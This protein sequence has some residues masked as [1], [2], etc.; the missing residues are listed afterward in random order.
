MSSFNKED[1][2]LNYVLEKLKKEIQ[3]LN[4]ETEELKKRA[5]SL[6]FEDKKR[7]EH[8]NV[9]TMLSH[10]LNNINRY[11][12]MI[13]NPYFARIDFTFDGKK[14]RNQIYIGKSGF[15]TS[16]EILV[17]DWRAPISNLYYE[18]SI[19]EA[20]YDAP[21]GIVKG[22]LS[23]KRQIIIEN[24]ILK[25][26]LDSDLISSDKLLQNHLNVNADNRMKTIV[27]SIQKE[28]NS[29]IRRPMNKSLIVQGVA[30]SGKTSVA[31]TRALHELHIIYNKKITDVFKN[32]VSNNINIKSLK[33]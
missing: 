7:G 13:P 23:L 17:T 3:I 11:Q 12:S 26:I 32:N 6:S 4:V 14:E 1:E 28:Q 18:N 21:S 2:R 27:A 16:Q 24:S 22:L 19:G 25:K 15:S 33:K 10:Q 30:G 29:I 20:E 8:F 9:N 31:S 5:I